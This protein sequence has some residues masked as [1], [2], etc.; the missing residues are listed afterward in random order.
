M[1]FD[2]VTQALLPR[3]IAAA[4]LLV[5][6]F[7][8][9]ATAQQEPACRQPEPVCAARAA[10]FAIAGPGGIGSATRLSAT[11]LVTT[12]HLI[13]DV[14][15]VELFLPDGERIRAEVVPSAYPADLILLSAPDLPQGPAIASGDGIAEAPLFTVGADISFGLIRAYDPGAILLHPAEGYPLAR[16]HH[17]AYGQPA[18]SG[19][20]LVGADGRLAGIVAA[21]GDGRFEA[22]PAKAITALRA[23]SGAAFSAESDEI[24][25]AIRICTLNLDRHRMSREPLTDQDAR[26]LATSCSR[27]RN[28]QN[29]DLAAQLLGTKGRFDESIA[30]FEAALAED[31]HALNARAGLAVTYHL[32][33]RYEEEI[34][35][36]VF[37]ME[38]LPDD[39]QILRLALQAGIWGGDRAL[40]ER[41]YERIEA[42]NP[43]MLPVAKRFL[44]APPPRPKRR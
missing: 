3:Q 20:A 36:L 37:L 31:P 7:S 11:E 10:V 18:H 25:A 40:A 44:E 26:A 9:P 28:R 34:P 21:G 35:H 1:Q 32:A 43:K 29:M 41:A 6:L 5:F 22:I 15:E 33:A 8:G 4:L 2:K 42:V 19:G 24:G 39:H 30:L 12:R 14:K 17:T 16:L 13:A 38:H 27:S 23:K